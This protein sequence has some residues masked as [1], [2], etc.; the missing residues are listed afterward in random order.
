M[1]SGV[2]HTRR[3]GEFERFVIVIMTQDR[4]MTSMANTDT[5]VQV[6]LNKTN[7]VE[8]TWGKSVVVAGDKTE[9]IR[10][11]SDVKATQKRLEGVLDDLL[12]TALPSAQPGGRD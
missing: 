1:Y 10:N 5:T 2:L 12:P 9:T 6:W 8:A 7:K 11:D 4:T 3:D